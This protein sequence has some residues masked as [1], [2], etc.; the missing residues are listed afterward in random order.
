MSWEESISTNQPQAQ[1]V[2]GQLQR[3]KTNLS[4]MEQLYDVLGT[5]ENTLRERQ[6]LQTLRSETQQLALQIKNE[7][8]RDT[9]PGKGK[10]VSELATLSKQFHEL[11]GR[12]RTKEQNL[13]S[14]IK[15]LDTVEQEDNMK[16]SRRRQ[17]MN[18]YKVSSF[19]EVD[20]AIINETNK[21]LQQLES[22]MRELQ[23]IVQ[24]AHTMVKTQGEDVAKIETTTTVARSNVET[25]RHETEE[26]EDLACGIRKKYIIIGILAIVLLLLII[27]GI[28]LGVYFA[29]K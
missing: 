28:A 10:Q 7:L 21:D 13:V 15:A 8:S 23:G 3:M 18:D 11:A 27:G 16:M 20:T 1:G 17:T 12:I 2:S 9:S 25:A 6:E 19:K 29:T 5:P 22:D 24:D 26:A 14:E 4:R